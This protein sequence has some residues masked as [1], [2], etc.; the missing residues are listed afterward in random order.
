MNEQMSTPLE[1]KERMMNMNEQMS[2]PLEIKERMAKIKEQII[3]RQR[4]INQISPNNAEEIRN[5]LAL[6]RNPQ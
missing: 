6:L 4:M 5:I 1:I 3:N 2:T